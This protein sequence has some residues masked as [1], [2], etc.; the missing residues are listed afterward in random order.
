MGYVMGE[1]G[2][3]FNLPNIRAL[4]QEKLQEGDV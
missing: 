1:R 2:S 3:R 4:A